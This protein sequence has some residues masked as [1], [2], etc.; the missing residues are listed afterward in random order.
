MLTRHP[1]RKVFEYL[2]GHPG[3]PDRETRLKLFNV[4]L[5]S[6]G[7]VS[8]YEIGERTKTL[9]KSCY[10]YL[11]AVTEGH[12]CETTNRI[13]EMLEAVG[14]TVNDLEVLNV[15]LRDRIVNARMYDINVKNLRLA[16]DIDGEQPTLDEVRAKAI[17]WEFCRT[18]IAEYASIMENDFP[19]YQ[20]R[21]SVV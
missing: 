8:S 20:D 6:A 12:A 10:P 17:V 21:K 18:H 13:F 2:A 14:L 1:W 15:H 5:L 11:A 7:P 4:A 16:L 3:I 9:V 19:N